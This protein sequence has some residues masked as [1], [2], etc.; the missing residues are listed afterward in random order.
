MILITGASG[1]SGGVVLAAARAAGL[2]VTALYRARTDAAAAPAGV[3]HVIAD[4]ADRAALA[5]ALAGIETVYLVC[6]PIPQLVELETNVIEAAQAAGVRHVLL[7]SALGAGRWHK[8]Y[9]AWHTR[10]EQT[11][12]ASGIAYTIIRP[13]GFMQNFVTY[14]GDTIRAQNAF[15]GAAGEAKMSLIDVRD[16]GEAAAAI[17][18]NPAAHAGRIYELNG[19]EPLSNADAAALISAAVGRTVN[20]EDI[21]EEA[22]RQAML[23]AG[24]PEWQVTA[25]LELQEYYR[26]G[27]C[28][29]SDADLVGLLGHRARRFAAWAVEN[30]STFAPAAA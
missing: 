9:P 22:Q 21:P 2:P 4:F 6:A 18:A 5:T 20:Y 19:P 27:A 24:M 16:I 7:N 26:T 11:L 25:I 15:Y 29:G 3:P 23:G 1:L 12:H 13:N 10:V 14:N 8:S 17:L 30:A 28:A